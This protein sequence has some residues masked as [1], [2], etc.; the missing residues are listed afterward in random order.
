LFERHVR[1]ALGS[2][3]LDAGFD[4]DAEADAVMALLGHKGADLVAVRHVDIGKE[5]GH[6][7]GFGT[8]LATLSHDFFAE[9]DLLLANFP[10]RAFFLA[11]GRF[12]D[13]HDTPAFVL[14]HLQLLTFFADEWFGD[15]FAGFD[16]ALGRHAAALV[17]LVF[18]FL[19]C[20]TIDCLG[21]SALFW[22]AFPIRT[23]TITGS[24]LDFFVAGRAVF[25]RWRDNLLTWGAANRIANRAI[26]IVLDNRRTVALVT[27][28]RVGDL[29]GA[30][31]YNFDVSAL[32][33]F[34]DDDAIFDRRFRLLA[35][36]DL[37][38]G[39]GHAFPRRAFL[40]GV[41]HLRA[42]FAVGAFV[43]ASFFGH[44]YMNG[45]TTCVAFLHNTAFLAN[46]VALYLFTLLWCAFSYFNLLVATE[47]ILFAIWN[48][49]LL[50]SDSD[51][52][53]CA[54][55]LSL[56][57]WFAVSR[58]CCDSTEKIICAFLHAFLAASG[59]GAMLFDS[60]T[61]AIFGREHFCGRLLDVHTFRG[62]FIRFAFFN[63]ESDLVHF[64]LAQFGSF[65]LQSAVSW[66]RNGR[67]RVRCENKD[68]KLWFFDFS[69]WLDDVFRRSLSLWRL[70]LRLCLHN[71]FAALEKCWFI[72]WQ[73]AKFLQEFFWR[74]F[75]D[76]FVV[77]EFEQLLLLVEELIFRIL[78]VFRRDD[79]L[80]LLHNLVDSAFLH[81]FLDHF[82]ALFVVGIHGD[83]DHF[84][85][86]VAFLLVRFG[87]QLF[88]FL[89]LAAAVV[90]FCH[91][92]PTLQCMGRTAEQHREWSSPGRRLFRCIWD[93][94]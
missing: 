29:S 91:L 72:L 74:H 34:G 85:A 13:L 11:L 5:L 49:D 12:A 55:L 41:L 1:G 9:A 14:L 18:Q 77:G 3:F 8:L 30:V 54:R 68:F 43:R 44:A 80:G 63:R 88:A 92:R 25:G 94:R 20:G 58:F 83:C 59:V 22:H 32:V 61:F 21:R 39:F 45:A 47:S 69:F 17:D 70:F 50:V 90:F 40:F 52:L 10:G 38:R 67:A 65:T 87:W 15:L 79:V 56:F 7:H 37:R 19:A 76:D 31:R 26:A 24:L 89:D 23:V 73:F 16:D 6:L 51:R 36:L 64:A 42:D 71:N 78:I 4:V 33:D 60:L 84:F 81:A 46:I 82:L 75:F 57:R 86:E 35:A 62:A 53:F 28:M 48:T 2:D 27:S 66:F 93:G